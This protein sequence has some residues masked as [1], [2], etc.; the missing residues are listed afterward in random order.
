MGIQTGVIYIVT[1]VHQSRRLW[2]NYPVRYGKGGEG[3]R[4]LYTRVYDSSEGLAIE[5]K[6]RHRYADLVVVSY[7]PNLS[8]LLVM[9]SSHKSGVYDRSS[10]AVS[11]GQFADLECHRYN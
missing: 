1:F 2:I 7:S 9:E 5:I 6:Q 3:N 4:R 10:R 8:C 11:T